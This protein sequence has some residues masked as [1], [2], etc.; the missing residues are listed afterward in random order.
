MSVT[1]DEEMVAKAWKMSDR[2]QDTHCSMMIVMI[3]THVQL[4]R[5]SRAK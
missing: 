4:E 5:T 3:N 1:R 2:Q